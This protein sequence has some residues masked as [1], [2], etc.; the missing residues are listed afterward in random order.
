MPLTAEPSL[1]PDLF[2]KP[3]TVK[4][5]ASQ[6]LATPAH[7]VA[8]VTEKVKSYLHF[9]RRRRAGEAQIGVSPS[10]I[11]GNSFMVYLETA[12]DSN[13]AYSVGT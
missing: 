9:T 10:L 4:V 1:S 12:L 2:L 6:V 7:T 8:T 13:S 11:H 3:T 5:A